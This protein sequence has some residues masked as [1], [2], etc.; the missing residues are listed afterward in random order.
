MVL[1]AEN[2]RFRQKMASF[3]GF[4]FVDWSTA[5]LRLK[6]L[7]TSHKTVLFLI[8]VPNGYVFNGCHSMLGI[9]SKTPNNSYDCKFDSP[10]FF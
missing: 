7:R 9:L 8:G 10:F 5:A 6:Y 4:N 1:R 2:K 3:A